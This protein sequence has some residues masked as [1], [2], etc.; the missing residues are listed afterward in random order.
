MASNNPIAKNAW[1]A[2]KALVFKARKGK[3]SYQRN[4][5][6]DHGST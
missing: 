6:V 4:K 3:G 1:K 2:N 5:G